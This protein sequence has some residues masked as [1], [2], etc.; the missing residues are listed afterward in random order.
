MFQAIKRV[1]CNNKKKSR[2]N[3]FDAVNQTILQTIN[4]AITHDIDI[5]QTSIH[6]NI[7]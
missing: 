6:S 3:H 1:S 5:L 2:K 7:I 4:T